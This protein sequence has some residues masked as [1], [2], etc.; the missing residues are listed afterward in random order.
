MDELNQDE[1]DS[2]GDESREFFL[3]IF[4]TQG[5]ALEPLELAHGLIDA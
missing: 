3:H 2:E 1:A 4:A 5:D